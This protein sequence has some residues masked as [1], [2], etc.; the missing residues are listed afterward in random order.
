MASPWRSTAPT[1]STTSPARR[2]PIRALIL[3][4]EQPP[5]AIGPASYLSEVV[6]L[7]GGANAFG[8]LPGASAPVSLEAIAARDPDV[9]LVLGASRPAAFGRPE[10][11]AVRAV[12]ER[13][14]VTLE[15]SEWD[16]PG[17][18]TPGAVRALAARLAELGP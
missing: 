5:I 6:V 8:D 14:V 17:P 11:Q 13:R 18:R 1:D 7:A 15:G 2:E 12:R 10:W 4:G 16:R 9:V 3:V